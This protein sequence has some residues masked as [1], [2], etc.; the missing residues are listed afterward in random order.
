MKIMSPKLVDL[1][2]EKAFMVFAAPI[3]WACL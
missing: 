3:S 1:E 2:V